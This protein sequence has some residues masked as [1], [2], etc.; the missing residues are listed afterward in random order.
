K[1]PDAV[2]A[3]V[4]TAYAAFERDFLRPA[5]ERRATLIA[6]VRRGDASESDLP[7]DILTVLLLH[8]EESS[9]ELADVWRVVREVAAYLKDRTHT[10]AQTLVNALD[11]MFA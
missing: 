4:R 2:R 3:L 10:S 8:R 11:L 5:W 7:Q 9:L 1:D 6:A